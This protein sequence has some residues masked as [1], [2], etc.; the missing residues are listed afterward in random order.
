MSTVETATADD[1]RRLPYGFQDLE[2]FHVEETDEW[3]YYAKWEGKTVSSNHPTGP[4][5]FEDEER[6]IT[7]A[8]WNVLYPGYEHIKEYSHLG[9]KIYNPK[10]DEH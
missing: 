3:S 4:W 5:F 9:G 7:K 8:D 2:V 10:L 1:L 6:E